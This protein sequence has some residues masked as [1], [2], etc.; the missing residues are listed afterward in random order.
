[1]TNIKYKNQKEKSISQYAGKISA[2]LGNMKGEVNLQWDSVAKAKHYVIQISQNKGQNKRIDW[3]H[4]DIIT[5]PHYT[6][7]GLNSGKIYSFRIAPVYTK[8][9]GAWSEP[10]EKKV[11]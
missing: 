6:I 7:N 8:G 1:M 11:K 2:A 9:Q 4:I 10:V 5:D 3:K